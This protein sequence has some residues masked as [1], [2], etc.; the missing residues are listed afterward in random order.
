[1]NHELLASIT[2]APGA[3]GHEKP[4]RDLVM[5]VL[6]PHVDEIYTDRMGNLIARKKGTGPRVMMAAHLD[7]ISLITTKVDK[8][9]FIR[10]ST[11]G[12][13]DAETLVTQRVVIHGKETLRGVIGSKP[14]HIQ[15]D[16]EKKEKSKL[17]NLYIDTGILDHEKVKELV[18]DGTPVTREKNL[19][20]MGD[21]VTSKSLDNRV[22]VYILAEALMQA[23]S[24][25]CDL[26]AV[27][28]VQE[29]VGV[30]GARVASNAIQ[31]EI[32]IALDITLANDLPG[33]SDHQKCT[34]LGEGIGIKV[35]D[36]SIICTPSL[37]QHLEKLA[38]DNS[39]PVQREVLTAGGTDTSAMQYLMGIGSHVTSISCPTRYVHSMV[40]TCAVKDI[41]AGIR[42][43]RTCIEQIGNYSF[44]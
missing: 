17:E 29:E 43:T 2:E 40:E 36:K 41:E 21:C 42:L 34:T 8:E 37:V 23:G 20:Q 4:V 22:S 9:G 31:P 14:I 38:E 35:M 1:M 44:E 39:I 12:G 18:P 16:S 25:N 10:F 24:T 26:Y 33:V 28:T 3:P 11:L 6:E 5:N 7:E 32:G 15:S 19:V 27:F 30:R 13:F